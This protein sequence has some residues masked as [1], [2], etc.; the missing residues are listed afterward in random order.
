M[1][2]HVTHYLLNIVVSFPINIILKKSKN[3]KHVT[4]KQ[5]KF[6]IT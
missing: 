5:T 4:K 1:N 2:E 3:P 6:F